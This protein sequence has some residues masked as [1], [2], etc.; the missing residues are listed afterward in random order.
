MSFWKSIFRESDEFLEYLLG[1]CY[2]DALPERSNAKLGPETDHCLT[3]P[4]AGHGSTELVGLTGAEARQRHGH[5]EDLLLV[6]NNT[7]GFAQHRFQRGMIVYRRRGK[8]TPIKL[9][10]LDI[11]VHGAADDWSRPHDRH[12]HDKIFETAGLG[13]QQG[14]DL[15]SAFDLK[16]ADRV[17]STDHVIDRLIGKI[18]SA[19]IDRRLAVGGDQA[20]CLFDEREH[21]QGEEIDLDEPGI[22]TGILVPL[23]EIAPLHGGGLHRHQLDEGSRGDDHPAGMLANVSGK[24]R[25]FPGQ[26]YQIAPGRRLQARR[27]LRDASQLQ[28]E[29]S[30]LTRLAE[31]GDAV[32]IS[33][34][35]AERLANITQGG[36]ETIGGESADERGMIGTE[37][38]VDAFDQALADLAR[39]VEI[40]VRDGA[41]LIVDEPAEHQVVRQ[42]IDVGKSNQ[43]ADDRADGGPSPASGRE[44]GGEAIHT[45]D[46]DRDLP[47]QLQQ[48]AVEQEKAG[49]P[50]SGDQLQF[51]FQSFLCGWPVFAVVPAAHFGP[52]DPGEKIV[53]CLPRRC[54]IARKEVGKIAREIE[55]SAALG[56]NG[57]VVHSFRMGRES[58]GRLF[59]RAKKKLRVR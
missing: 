41:H 51:L 29:V 42:R 32:E 47:R 58:R 24:P 18:D 26:L 43:V 15:S 25:K 38:L 49:K 36:A 13:T 44:G 56:E 37:A 20:Q 7:Q 14:L 30:G 40:D 45:A 54:G 46:L 27:V 5:P 10:M 12:L 34:R 52:T 22:I 6:E 57:G 39:K 2:I 19:E 55:R 1:S 35:D 50:V 3:R 17:S 4:L 48:I 28:A 23:T 21:P 11:R 16:S 59:W 33:D 9:S 53:G 31:L 8:S